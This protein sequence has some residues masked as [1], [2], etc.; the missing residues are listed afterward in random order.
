MGTEYVP[1]SGD[2]VIG[3]T[4]YKDVVKTFERTNNPQYTPTETRT[5]NQVISGYIPPSEGE[6]WRLTAIDDYSK[7]GASTDLWKVLKDA[8]SNE[9]QLLVEAY[10][11]GNASGNAETTLTDARV[12]YVS[13]PVMD[14]DTQDI[15]TFEAVF[16]AL[17]ANVAKA[18]VV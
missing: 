17:A 7:G 18:L 6:Q 8:F 1:S 5:L 3:S 2:V 10:P 15:A 16:H 13:E 12:L 11:A 9:T 14:A 4:S